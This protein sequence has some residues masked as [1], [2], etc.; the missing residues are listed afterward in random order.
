MQYTEFV[1][2]C[3]LSVLQLWGH[4]LRVCIRKIYEFRLHCLHDKTHLSSARWHHGA[5]EVP[6]FRLFTSRHYH[7]KD[8]MGWHTVNHGTTWDWQ[9]FLKFGIDTLCKSTMSLWSEASTMIRRPKTT[10]S[11]QFIDSWRHECNDA[12]LRVNQSKCIVSDK[13]WQ[14]RQASLNM[15]HLQ[16]VVTGWQFSGYPINHTNHRNTPKFHIYDK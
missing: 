13:Y 12:Q 9:Y 8:L 7:P 2:H 11:S 4:L 14:I 10:G 6:H 16:W 1:A 15:V 5:H 3:L